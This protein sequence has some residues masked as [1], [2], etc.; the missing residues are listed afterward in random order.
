MINY[1]RKNINP[2][3]LAISI[4]ILFLFNSFNLNN[5]FNQNSNFMQF[6]VNF[7]KTQSN[8][9]KNPISKNQNISN[10]EEKITENKIIDTKNDMFNWYI[11]IP[12]I[13]LKAEISEGTTKQIMDKYVGHFEE[14][15]KSIG[16]IGL[17]AHNRGYE[18]NYFENLKKL[19]EDDKIIYHYNDIIKTYIV[20]KHKIISDTDWTY[21]EE[22]QSNTITL[23]T[24]VENKPEYR[25]CI[26]GIEKKEE[27]N[28]K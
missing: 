4:I 21:L 7:I 22:T 5:R 25:R 17:A 16:N 18:N 11:E 13:S 6:E 12:I 23:I 3:I 27:I 2:L 9:I 10:S 15:S 8:T 24:C 20:T 19:K 14:T 1:T 28:E 26:Q